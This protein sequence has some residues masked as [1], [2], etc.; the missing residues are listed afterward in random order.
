MRK[1]ALLLAII[2]L[3]SMPLS[4]SAEPRALTIAPALAFEGTTAKCEASVVGNNTSEYIEVTMK[5]KW[6]IFTVESW[7]SSGY[8]YVYMLEE[9]SVNK[10]WTY[11]LVVEVTFDGVEKSP[12]SISGTC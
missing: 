5:L 12:V 3:I 10:G 2:L 1:T 8:G 11:K 7:T 4:V 9:H 6:G